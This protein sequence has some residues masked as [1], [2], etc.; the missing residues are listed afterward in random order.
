MSRSARIFSWWALSSPLTYSTRFS[1]R[2]SMVWR[3]RVDLPIPGS[4]PNNTMEYWHET[5]TQY[6]VQFLVVHINARVVMGRDVTKAKHLVLSQLS[7]RRCRSRCSSHLFASVCHFDLL[8]RVPLSAR[9]TF[10]DP[11]CRFLSAVLADIHCLVFCH[12]DCEDTKN[13]RICQ[14]FYFFLFF[15]F[16]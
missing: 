6:A 16:S 8:E 7:A 3:E 10:S 13:N 1:G 11:F 5:A 15:R 12:I 2:F 9:R 4:P 14:T